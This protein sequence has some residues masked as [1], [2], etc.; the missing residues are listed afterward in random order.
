MIYCH[1]QWI[2]QK[3]TRTAFPLI[4]TLANVLEY[5]NCMPSNVILK[6]ESSDCLKHTYVNQPGQDSSIFR[7]LVEHGEE[8]YH[9]P[10]WR[11]YG[12]VPLWF[13]TCYM[14]QILHLG[15]YQL[16]F[17]GSTFVHSIITKPMQDGNLQ[18][19]PLE[20]VTPLKNIR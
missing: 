17:F 14:D 6:Q 1:L 19:E 7:E 12:I 2:A 13:G 9:D 8:M 4:F 16:F 18:V 10:N 15:E 3:V 20:G 11:T 5:V